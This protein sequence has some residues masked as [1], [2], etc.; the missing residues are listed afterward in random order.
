[1]NK[2]LLVSLMAV[3]S[4]CS[5]FGNSDY[6]CKGL[7]E[8]S[9]CISTRDLYE[10]TSGGENS[11]S[12]SNISEANSPES[13]KNHD[14]EVSHSQSTDPVIDNFVTPA[15][16]DRPVPIRTPAQVMRIWVASWEDISSGALITPGYI[17]TEIE[18]RRWVIGKSESAASSQAK[19]FKPLESSGNKTNE[20]KM[21]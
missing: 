3:L 7:P 17:Y 11:S 19:I 8:G 9:R 2:L 15:L 21:D 6:G 14:K 4:G 12:V 10:A 1:M 13:K 5:S 20:T 18:P 16:P